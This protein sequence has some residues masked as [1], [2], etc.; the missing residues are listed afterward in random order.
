MPKSDSTRT[1][2]PAAPHA[3]SLEEQR[4]DFTSEGAPLPG[5]VASAKPRR[6]KKNDTFL[7][8]GDD[9][10]QAEELERQQDA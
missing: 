9:P 6:Q 3:K 7:E 5:K 1:I 2:A 10:A 8:R 4:T